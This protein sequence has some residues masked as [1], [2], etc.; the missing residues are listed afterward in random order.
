MTT[1]H[2]V[3]ASERFLT[4]EEPL[5]E[6]LRERQRNYTETGKII[7]FWLVRQPAFLAASELA[8]LKATIPQPAAAVV[9]T[10]PTF[11]TFLKLRLEYVVVGSFEAPSEVI[12]DALASAV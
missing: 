6:V 10:D 9:S 5:E 7:D 4:V 3:A 2:F 1:Y 11:I 8:E 12:P